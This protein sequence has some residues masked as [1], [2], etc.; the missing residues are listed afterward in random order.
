[1]RVTTG[2]ERTNRLGRGVAVVGGTERIRSIREGRMP[3]AS[4]TERGEAFTE[5]DDVRTATQ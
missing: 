4:G 1:M 3:E 2:N 5:R